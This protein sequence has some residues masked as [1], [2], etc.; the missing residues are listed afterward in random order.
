MAVTGALVV[1]L[2]GVCVSGLIVNFFAGLTFFGE[3]LHQVDLWHEVRASSL[4]AALLL[5]SA[6]ALRR[7]RPDSLFPLTACVLGGLWLLDVGVSLLNLP[8]AP[9]GGS[10]EP[11]WW[12]PQLFF[13]L[14]TTWPIVV[15]VLATPWIRGWWSPRRPARPDPSAALDRPRST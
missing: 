4:T 5:L 14:P 15:L 9:G 2:V 10:A 7:L 11:W 1:A 13:S 3:P 12:S 6:P 8:A